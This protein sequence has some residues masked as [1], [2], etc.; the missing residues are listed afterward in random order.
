MPHE[1]WGLNLMI[2]DF[3]WEYG[4]P[5]PS[6]FPRFKASSKKK[7][8]AAKEMMKLWNDVLGEPGEF[9]FWVNYDYISPTSSYLKV[10]PIL[11]GIPWLHYLWAVFRV[12][13]LNGFTFQM[14]GFNVTLQKK[15]LANTDNCTMWS[16]MY[17]TLPI[18]NSSRCLTKSGQGPRSESETRHENIPSAYRAG[19]TLSPKGRSDWDANLLSYD[20]QGENNL[21][22]K[23]T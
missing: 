1:S 17:P 10:L 18:P 13:V 22:M 2:S 6:N 20:R 16:K 4:I 21:C 3:A 11:H 12:N 9:W 23:S 8:M 19:M 7:T 5:Q 15:T 14:D